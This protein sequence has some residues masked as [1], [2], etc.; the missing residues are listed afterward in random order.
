MGMGEMRQLG[1]D[2]KNKSSFI[3]PSLRVSA[4]PSIVRTH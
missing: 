1:N 3:Q 4:N 2:R